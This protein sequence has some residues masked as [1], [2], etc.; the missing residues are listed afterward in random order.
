MA[1][2][3]KQVHS[4]DASEYAPNAPDRS[5]TQRLDALQEANRIRFARANL[6]RDLKSG[7]KSIQDIIL[8]PPE[9]VMTMKVFDLALAC[10]KYGRVKVNKI[11]TKCRISPSK[12][13]GGLSSRQRGEMISM[14]R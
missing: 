14:L 9:Y 4:K 8:N 5:L 12:T 6:K 11:F 7:R 2:M 3:P 10:P 1:P 13:I